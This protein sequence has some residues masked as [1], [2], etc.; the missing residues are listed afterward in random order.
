[1]IL[2]SGKPQRYFQTHRAAGRTPAVF[3]FATDGES[4]NPDGNSAAGLICR[5]K[6]FS[7]A[8]FSFA[9]AKEK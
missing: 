7:F 8:Y 4:K 2:C 5:G 6:V 1:L 9:R 3:R